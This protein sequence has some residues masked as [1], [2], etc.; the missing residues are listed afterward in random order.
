MAR[1]WVLCNPQRPSQS[2][3]W[4]AGLHLQRDGKR[5]GVA[6]GLRR[7]GGRLGLSFEPLGEASD[8]L[9]TPRR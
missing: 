3:P 2:T 5:P 7:R 9:P 1:A 6:A 4:K 8:F